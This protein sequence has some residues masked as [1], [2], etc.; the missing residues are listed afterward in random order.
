MIV[1]DSFKLVSNIP[2]TLDLSKNIIDS[3]TIEENSPR[4]VFA[5]LELKK[6]S[7]A[8]FTTTKIFDIISNIKKR[9]YIQIINF[10]YPL[11]TSYNLP[12]N[13]AIINLKPFEV[14]EISSMSAYDLYTSI[15]YAYSFSMLSTK[16]YKISESYAKIIINFLLSFYVKAFGRDYGLV[17]IYSSAIP[18]L[19]FLIACYILA[20]FFG[21][22]TN[23]NLFTS[24]STLAPYMYSNEIDQLL[25]YNF[26]FI[27][28]FIKATSDLKVMPGI[29]IAKFTSKLYRFYGINVLVALEDC[30]RFFSVILSSSIPGAR[31]VPRHLIQVNEKE[32]YKMVEIMGGMFK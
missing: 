20:A 27:D 28:Q 2:N 19:K 26:S 25:K 21:H 31:V 4:H 1:K 29:T 22:P 3:Y 15:V 6:K 24:A 11:P 5:M 12:T 32:Y 14:N 30:A 13:T 7:I 8:H 17:A 9:E 23:K 16:K 10:D 18:K